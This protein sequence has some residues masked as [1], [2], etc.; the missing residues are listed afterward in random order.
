MPFSYTKLWV[1]LVSRGW[2]KEDLRCA[3][4]A[5]PTT[6][7]AMGRNENVSMGVIGRICDVLDCQPG[8][9]LEYVPEDKLA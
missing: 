7:A 8:D 5:S 1:Q 6:I 2:N 3:I 4:G 9:I